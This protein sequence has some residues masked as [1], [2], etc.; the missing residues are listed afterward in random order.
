M[1]IRAVIVSA[2]TCAQKITTKG[3]DGAEHTWCDLALDSFLL[4]SGDVGFLV[5]ES[6]LDDAVAD[7]PADLDLPAIALAGVREQIA[8]HHRRSKEALDAAATLRPLEWALEELTGD[9]GDHGDDYPRPDSDG[10]L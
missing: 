10:A 5:R 8:A 3:E 6:H 1:D 4:D 2:T 7:Y 9:H